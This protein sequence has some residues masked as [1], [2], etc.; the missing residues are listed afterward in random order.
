MKGPTKL[1]W[2]LVSMND[3]THFMSNHLMLSSEPN[4]SL[5]VDEIITERQFVTLPDIRSTGRTKCVVAT[6]QGLIPGFVATGL[7][8]MVLDNAPFEVLSI[9]LEELIRMFY[10]T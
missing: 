8:T 10:F 7:S 1:C 9:E 6:P 5:F 4:L 2:T 3:G